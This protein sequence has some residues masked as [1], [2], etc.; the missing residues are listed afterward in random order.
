MWLKQHNKYYQDISIDLSSLERLPENGVPEVI[1]KSIQ[2]TNLKINSES[3]F[4]IANRYIKSIL[5]F[6]YW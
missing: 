5:L 1:L 2:V 4:N 6:I 3:T